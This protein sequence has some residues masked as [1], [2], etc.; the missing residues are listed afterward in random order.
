MA[1]IGYKYVNPR[2]QHPLMHNIR[3]PFVDS[4]SDSTLRGRNNF[5]KIHCYGFRF[6]LLCSVN[7]Y[8]CLLGIRG[9]FFFPRVRRGASMSV[10][11]RSHESPS[12]EIAQETSLLSGVYKVLRDFQTFPSNSITN[13]CIEKTNKFATMN[14]RHLNQTLERVFHLESK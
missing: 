3:F 10:T 12:P 6:P 13:K 4:S 9:L 2:K 11:E 8:Q 14:L 1:S 5:V 7:I